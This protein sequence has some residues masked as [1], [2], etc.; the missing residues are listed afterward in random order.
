LKTRLAV[1][2]FVAAS[3][4]VVLTVPADAAVPQHVAPDTTLPCNDGSGKVAQFWNTTTLAAKNPCRTA[5]L[6]FGFGHDAEGESSGS[7]LNVAP[8]AHFNT[9]RAIGYRSDD[10]VG[11]VYGVSLGQFSCG[12]DGTWLVAKNSHGKWQFDHRCD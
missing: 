3:S 1:A 12:F 7:V 4:L 5:Y 11:G 6:S 2:A 8:G 10:N 9:G